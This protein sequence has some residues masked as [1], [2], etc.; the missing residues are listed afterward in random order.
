MSETYRFRIEIDGRGFIRTDDEALIERTVEKAL[1]YGRN[2]EVRVT[3]LDGAVDVY[4]CERRVM[5]ER[6]AERA[7]RA[8]AG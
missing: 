2:H 4:R 1:T 5:R 3:H 7:L 8:L 6:R